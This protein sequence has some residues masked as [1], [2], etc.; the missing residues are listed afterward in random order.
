M[1]FNNYEIINQ[2]DLKIPLP[3]KACLFD[4]EIKNP[5]NYLEGIP[6]SFLI[7]TLIKKITIERL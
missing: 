4:E 5:V 6:K 2:M 1:I 3:F 7:K